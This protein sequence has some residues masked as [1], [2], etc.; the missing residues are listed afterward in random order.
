MKTKV[1]LLSMLILFLSEITESQI[2]NAGFEE[3]DSIV[4]VEEPVNWNT[5][6]IEKFISVE[7]VPCLTQGQYAIKVSSNGPSFEGTSSGVAKTRFKP[8]HIYNTLLADIKIDTIDSGK[9]EI[10]LNQIVG[11]NVN[12]I[13]YWTKDTTTNGINNIEIL[14]DYETLDTIEILIIAHNTPGPL[15]S[16]GYSEIV[17][18]NMNFANTNSIDDIKTNGFFVFPNP[19]K[20]ILSVKFTVRFDGKLE[21]IDNEGRILILHEVQRK[22]LEKL[23]I[24]HLSNGI[25]YIK[26]VDNNG[27]E[28]VGKFVVE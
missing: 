12:Q 1:L 5:K 2:P 23:D 3:W 19:S 13:G 27:K 14:V 10:I 11:G 21:I 22:V 9:V 18:D 16:I 8:L 20:N 28:R 4:G 26:T 25:Y 24:S 6:N 17:V 7:K 15:G